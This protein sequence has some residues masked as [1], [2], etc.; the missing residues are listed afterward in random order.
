MLGYKWRGE[1]VHLHYDLQTV[2]NFLVNSL[3]TLILIILLLSLSLI[4]S[5][6]TFSR[7][8][9]LNLIRRLNFNHRLLRWG[10]FRGA[11][12]S[13]KLLYNGDDFLCEAV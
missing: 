3:Q 1:I 13:F 2:P 8:I 4:G 6:A 5:L 7:V 11:T 9:I 10:F 12:R